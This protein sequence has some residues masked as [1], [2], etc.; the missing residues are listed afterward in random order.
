MGDDANRPPT[1][2]AI[3]APGD[4]I[5]GPRIV[6]PATMRTYEIKGHILASLPKF[7]GAKNEDVMGFL[8]DM[9]SFVQNLTKV[10]GTSDNDLS[11]KFSPCA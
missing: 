10:Q 1:M 3:F 6:L 7:Y 5:P 2:G 8:Q 9:E 11:M 4:H